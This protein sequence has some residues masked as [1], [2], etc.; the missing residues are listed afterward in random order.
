MTEAIT[1]NEMGWEY[2]GR[3]YAS[4]ELAGEAQRYPWLTIPRALAGFEQG[5]GHDFPAAQVF[6]QLADAFAAMMKASSELEPCE[7]CGGVSWMSQGPLSSPLREG[8][9]VAC[10]ACKGTGK[11]PAQKVNDKLAVF[12]VACRDL[13][14]E[15]GP[16]PVDRDG[17]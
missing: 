5:E 16:P 17:F 12:S 3:T 13:A 6:D 9:L 14:W 7:E 10:P 4:I 15:I 11:S 8:S 2:Q 1:M